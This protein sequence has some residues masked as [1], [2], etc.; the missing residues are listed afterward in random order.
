MKDKERLGEKIVSLITNPGLL[1]ML[2]L[3]VVFFI[4]GINTM[5]HQIIGYDEG[6]NATVAANVARYGQYRVSYPFK[7][8]FYNMITTGTPVI[9]PT[10]VLYRIFGIGFITSG[11]VSLIYMSLAIVIIWYMFAKCLE[12]RYFGGIISVILVSF[13]MISDISV[14]YISTHLVGESACLFFLACAC[15]SF[16][17]GYTSGGN[18]PLLCA[19]IFI[20]ASFLTKSSMIFFVV[21][22]IGITILESIIGNLKISNSIS[23]FVGVAIGFASIDFYKYKVLGNYDGWV[24]WWKDEWNNMMSQSGQTIEKPSISDKFA[25]LK[26]IFGMN[27]YVSLFII[28]LPCV[29]YLLL[30]IYRFRKK[31]LKNKINTMLYCVALWG[32]AASSLE[33]FYLLF[34]GEGLMNERRHSVNELFV[35]IVA[36]V[37]IGH[38][39]IWI[40]SLFAKKNKC[41]SYIA[42]ALI[43][44]VALTAPPFKLYKRGMRY[45]DKKTVDDYD[46]KLM[47]EFLAEVD[48]LPS[49][50]RL[51]C[52][53]WWQEPNVTLFLDRDMRDIE[54]IDCEEE[55]IDGGYLLIGRRFDNHNIREVEERFDIELEKVNNLDVDYDAFYTFNAEELFSIYMINEK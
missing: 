21:S 38:G 17:Y 26:S 47:N 23:F 22:L 40:L 15:V 48:E 7:R 54:S 29:L 53:G 13:L 18:M 2:L 12:D 8:C 39:I 1:L 25:F 30:L 34:G 24:N 31:E 46:K 32:V 9:I 10:A 5:Q 42:I 19:G 4:D 55:T 20:S 41:F 44:V 49:D 51:Y 50:A 27:R 3:T 37:L 16:A 36:L 28:L 6:W 11:I 52:Y 43:I 33:I 14:P 45:I 35:K